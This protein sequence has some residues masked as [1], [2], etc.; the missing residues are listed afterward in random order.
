MA[1]IVT[2]H[3]DYFV[4]YYDDKNRN[5]DTAG[6][7]KEGIVYYLKKHKFKC[8]GGYYTCPWYFIDIVN[9]FFMPGRPGIKFG[10]VV[11]EHA[12][13]FEEFKTIFEIYDK[14]QGVHFMTTK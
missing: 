12:I 3:Y 1:T 2:N 9:K 5:I 8:M 14:Y 6:K 4:V 7:N 11:G 10:R 13:S